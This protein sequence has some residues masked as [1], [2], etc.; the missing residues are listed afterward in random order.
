MG[1]SRIKTVADRLFLLED[2]GLDRL[3][4]DVHERNGAHGHDKAVVITVA[5]TNGKGS[6]VATLEA[7]YCDAGYRVGAYTSP[8]LLCFNERIRLNQQNISDSTL[9]SAFSIIEE[10]RDSIHLTYF[11]MATLAA[12]WCFK[13]FQ[14]DV[15]ILEVGIGGRLDATN[16][17]DS[18]LA[19][20]TTIDF[21]H[22]EYLGDTIE[23]IA[24]EKA[25]ILREN[26]LLIY[27]D[28]R[29]PE[30]IRQ[31]AAR[32]NVKSCS[33]NE[34]YSFE[35]V[36][37]TLTIRLSSG[38]VLTFP[39]PKIHTK[40]AV[41]SILASRILAERLPVNA[42]SLKKSIQ[43]V[44][45]SG[46]LQ[47][48]HGT[49]QTIMDVSHNPQSVA[50]LAE[51]IQSLN[52]C[53]TIHAVFSGLKDKDLCGLIEPLYSHVHYWYSAVLEGKRA[54]SISTLNDAFQDVAAK[55]NG[56]LHELQFYASIILAYQAAI[57]CA[58]EGDLII[59]YGS[60]LVVSP[61]M[62][63]CAR[64]KD[65]KIKGELCNGSKMKKINID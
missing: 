22:E 12:L 4:R 62:L 6:T 17:I 3:R 36:D 55:N 25:G 13:Q 18:D 59:V 19:V 41:A 52:V 63:Y 14:P 48:I 50:L 64:S 26:S 31:Q 27:S 33:L 42:S 16:I 65:G 29:M 7:I 45:I 56:C 60:F 15:I 34:D 58:K 39:K 54:A 1:L 11:E 2:K 47:V 37:E 46:R 23:A 57:D 38:E 32:L 43:S 53:G 40:A 30:S 24:F 51:R 44:D 49:I 28:R 9:C 21:D 5:G 61:V 20:I 8:H 10:A 35:I